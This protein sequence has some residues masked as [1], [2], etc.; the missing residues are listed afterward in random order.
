M[1]IFFDLDGTFLNVAPRHYLVYCSTLEQFG[2][3]AL[4]ANEYW[5]LKRRKVNWDY[6]LEKSGVDKSQKSAFLEVFITKIE[7]TEYLK[8]DELFPFSMHILNLFSHYELY[9]VSLRRNEQ[10]LLSELQRLGIKDRFKRVLTG[11]SE[12]DGFDKKIE[13][14]SE[15][16]GS[17]SGTIIGDTEADIVAGKELGLTTVAVE[18]GIRD[19]E[20]L[21]ELK[22]DF[23]L[24]DISELEKVL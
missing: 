14:I 6:I 19:G 12:T 2:G 17:E 21:E 18:S 11:H 20:F 8:G 7:S 23:L 16:L 3:K 22:P 9:L 24:K 13:L 4:G 1:K 5:S 15:V 10:N